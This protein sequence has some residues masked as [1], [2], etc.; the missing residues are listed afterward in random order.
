MTHILTTIN[1]TA[2]DVMR[3]KATYAIARTTPATM[4]RGSTDAIGTRQGIFHIEI[5]QRRLCGSRTTL[6]QRLSSALSD[7][8]AVE[9]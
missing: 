8:T 9:V 6:H 7:L 5:F 4:I 1:K 3:T 2:M